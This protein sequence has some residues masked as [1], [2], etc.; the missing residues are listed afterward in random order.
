MHVNAPRHRAIAGHAERC[1]RAGGDTLSID[2]L[3]AS[4]RIPHLDEV[5]VG[6]ACVL[7][8]F[9]NRVCVLFDNADFIV[10]PQTLGTAEIGADGAGHT[11]A[12]EQEVEDLCTSQ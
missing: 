9:K 1:S 2:D 5:D 10:I 3:A 7:H 8:A 6:T 12:L 11:A 4:P